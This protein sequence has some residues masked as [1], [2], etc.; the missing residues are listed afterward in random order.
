MKITTS[1]KQSHGARMGWSEWIPWAFCALLIIGFMGVPAVPAATTIPAGPHSFYA[2]KQWS[3]GAGIMTTF[4]ITNPTDSPVQYSIEAFNSEDRPA[5]VLT[6][7][8]HHGVSR[9][10]GILPARG[11]VTISTSGRGIDHAALK[12]WARVD[13][14]QTLEVTTSARVFDGAKTASD[15]K[16][17]PDADLP[18]PSTTRGT[19]G[20]F[21]IQTSDVLRKHEYNFGLD[22]DNF[23]RMPGALD[24]TDYNVT[25]AYGLTDRL[26]LSGMVE[27]QKAVSVGQP[28]ML[29][30]YQPLTQPFYPGSGLPR[31]QLRTPNGYIP[32]ANCRPGYYNDIPLV[33]GRGF[34]SD[35]GDI[36]LNL[37]TDILSQS[38]GNPLG[39]GFDVYFKLPT[40]YDPNRLDRGRGTG[41]FET[42]ADLILSR[43]WNDLLGTHFNAG[44]SL[45]AAP[46]LNGVEVLQPRDKLNFGVGFNV[47]SSGRVQLI[48]E[49]LSTVYI[50]G[51]TPN[52]TFAAA[53]PVD[54]VIGLRFLP[55]RWLSFGAGYR[56]N[57]NQYTVSGI[58]DGN[59]FVAQVQFHHLPPKP[60]PVNHPPT[61]TCSA[62]PTTV[63][64]GQSV[65]LSASA[66]DPD[67]DPL[68]YVWHADTGNLS[69][70]NSS[71]TWDT[72]GVAAGSYTISVHVS[73]GRGG[74]ADCSSTIT[75]TPPPPARSWAPATR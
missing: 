33:S 47:P 21:H 6:N 22:A 19:T 30:T 32:C 17:V 20:L 56:R 37:K 48:G 11:I 73:D 41:S 10:V 12:G 5:A 9:L 40:T 45:L 38:R 62:S 31:L 42:G 29:S 55:F 50:G 23:D 60:V 16:H 28:N 54:G 72:A 46:E 3:D 66:S 52:T 71:A 58:G 69:Q 70:N 4:Q 53:D 67:N 43:V 26:E 24:I 13:A 44:Y 15:W 7:D 35:M 65:Q 18:R 39:L 27:A 63:M 75:V 61:V 57:L 36:Y 1:F 25:F 51:G 74:T 59:G 34:Q 64:T 14:D 8:N 2:V 68:T 49:L